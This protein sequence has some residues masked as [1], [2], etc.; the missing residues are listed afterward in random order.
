M[1]ILLRYRQTVRTQDTEHQLRGCASTERAKGWHQYGDHYNMENIQ[2]RFCLLVT[3]CTFCQFLLPERFFL[4]HCKRNIAWLL[5]G[6]VFLGMNNLCIFSAFVP[7]TVIVGCF[8]SAFSCSVSFILFTLL[9]ILQHLIPFTIPSY[10]FICVVSFISFLATTRNHPN[11]TIHRCKSVQ[12]VNPTFIAWKTFPALCLC[13]WLMKT[14]SDW[15]MWQDIFTVAIIAEW[16][17]H[18]LYIEVP[19]IEVLP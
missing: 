17:S 10:G 11:S 12:H 18:A 9:P 7:L 19:H 5:H 13:L 8:F 14:T 3:R 15:E 2:T 4:L 1:S 6:L 16:C